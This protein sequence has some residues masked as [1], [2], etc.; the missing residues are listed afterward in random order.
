MWAFI[1][2][3]GAQLLLA[4]SHLMMHRATA[5]GAMAVR[6]M[7][8]GRFAAYYWA[9]IVLGGVALVA[10]V[11]PSGGIGPLGVSGAVA[12]LIGLLAYEHAYVQSGQSVPLS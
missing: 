5:E 6:N 8:R 11:L 2:S 3:V 12:G 4:L 7:V 9:S 1:A 10:L